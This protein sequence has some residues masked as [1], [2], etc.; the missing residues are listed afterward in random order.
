[1]KYA[2]RMIVLL[3]LPLLSKADQGF[4]IKGKVT[5]IISGYVVIREHQHNDKAPH[6]PIPEK[7]R[8]VNGEFTYA[9]KLSRPELLEL[10]VSTKVVNIFLENTT[11]TVECSF[12]SLSG[13]RFKGGTLNDQWWRLMQSKQ[14]PLTYLEENPKLEISAW[15]AYRYALKYDKAVKAYD[16]LIPAAK[17]SFEG[18]ALL[19]RIEVYKHTSAGA[20]LPVFNMTDPAGKPFDIKTLTGKVVVLDFWASWCAPCR[21]YIP[22]LREHYNK[23]KDKEVVFISVSVDEDPTKWQTAMKELNMEWPQ[24]LAAG[25]FQEETGVRKLFNITGIPH[26]VVVDKAGKIAGS[27]DYS[28]KGRLEEVVQ[29]SL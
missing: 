15:I 16:Q 8:I 10:K 21:V 1:M 11:Y 20:P 27:L 28:E 7:V 4:V 23:F 25:G 24:V 26:V 6:E 17:N 3:L 2:V 5:G 14:A 18:K 12:D 19:E 13:D 29:K 22:T 9:G